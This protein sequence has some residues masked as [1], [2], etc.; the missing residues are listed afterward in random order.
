MTTGKYSIADQIKENLMHQEKDDTKQV[1]EARDIELD[2]AEL[3]GVA[4]GVVINH[5]EQYSLP[6]KLDKPKGED[7]NETK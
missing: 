2:D 6:D 5:E 1:D 4:G 3:E 7:V